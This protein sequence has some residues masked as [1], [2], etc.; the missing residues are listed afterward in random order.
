MRPLTLHV[1]ALSDSEYD[2]YTTSLADLA[3]DTPD[4]NAHIPHIRD[5]AQY[6]RTSV[7]VR[8]ARA[9]LRGRYSDV[10]ASDIDAILKL[11]CPNM[12]PSDALKGGQFFAALRLVMHAKS[13]RGVD[14]TLAFVQASPT[15]ASAADV[16]RP[17]SPAKRPVQAPPSHPDRQKPLPATTL[18]PETNPFVHRSMEHATAPPS[19]ADPEPAPVLPQKRPGKL[20]HNPFLA[21]DKPDVGSDKA[22]PSA[23]APSHSKLP[24]LPPR[25]PS[26]LAAPSRR[27]S[28]AATLSGPPMVSAKPSHVMS[29]IMR[30][31][32]EASKHAQSMKRAEEQLDRERV[33]QVLKTSSSSSSA[34]NTTHTPRT[35]SLSPSKQN[36]KQP[37]GYGV[38]SGSGSGA[39]DGATCV[40]PLPRCRKPSLPSSASSSALSLEQV[41]SASLPTPTTAPSRPPLPSRDILTISTA[42]T[43]NVGLPAVAGPGPIP[44]PTHP[45]RRPSTSAATEPTVNDSQSSS[46]SSPRCSRSKSVMSPPPVPPPPPRRKRPESM[47]LTPTSDLGDMPAFPPALAAHAR[48]HGR[49]ASFQGL[50]RHLSL[51][52]DRERDPSESSHIANIQKTLTNL[53][54]KAQPKLDAVRY[55]AEAGIS[56]RGYIHHAQLGGIR[57]HEEG[58]QGL[59]TDTQWAAANVDQ[60]PD[61]GPT[62]DDEP[63]S[64]DDRATQ[65]ATKATTR[66]HFL[67]ESDNLKWP[68]GEGWKP[69]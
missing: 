38:G 18:F 39:S 15:P 17:L 68:M 45:Y 22:L 61:S 58:E 54:L 67:A 5:D 44:P 35:R 52:R 42:H 27:S 3:T 7:G 69:L 46:P 49:T 56:K 47:Q 66:R 55:K 26:T 41:A 28:D 13:G 63:S 8:E 36:P 57:W 29:S 6:D 51:T 30:Q 50:S 60:D 2:L 14:R 11:F 12:L 4:G 16:P 19:P 62:T 24:P 21:R 48:T 25:K 33:L 53:Q 43:D 20:S 59:M 40:P 32:L 23:N 9:W 1:S 31:S 37:N 10:P 34:S 64:S 65:S